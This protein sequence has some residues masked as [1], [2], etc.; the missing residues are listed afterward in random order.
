MSHKFP[1]ACIPNLGSLSNPHGLEEAPVVHRPVD[2]SKKFLIEDVLSHA[3]YQPNKV[4]P[5]R[6]SH[7]QG[8][9][10]RTTRFTVYI[11]QRIV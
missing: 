8:D 3:L 10:L 7:L 2:G 5:P 4:K 11:V 9:R 1:K 6:S